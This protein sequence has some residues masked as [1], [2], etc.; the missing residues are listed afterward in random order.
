M[1]TMLLMA[2]LVCLACAMLAEAGGKVEAGLEEAVKLPRQWEYS[3]PLIAPED[4]RVEPSRAQ[5]DPTVVQHDGRWH[6]FMTVKLPGRSAIEYCAFEKWIDAQAAPRTL[7]PVCDTKYYCAPQVF[8][9]RPHGGWVLVYQVGGAAGT[10]KMQVAFSTT[11]TLADP[12]S[13][14]KAEPMLDGGPDDPR[15]VGGLDY[16]VI[17]DER[18]AHL[19]LTSNDG[20]MWLLA[21]N[22]ADFPYGWGDCKLALQGEVFE[23]SHTYRL[24][25]RD[26]YLTIIE[27]DGR[28]YF[29]AYLADRLDGEWTPL[30]DTES[31]PFAGAANIRPAAGVEPWTDNVSHGELLRA[32][33]DETMPLDPA[34]L[35]FVFQG[36]REKDKPGKGYGDYPWRIGILT[37]VAP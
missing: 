8:Y 26:A 18:W 16:W 19:F 13:W 10:D 15:E 9:F 12:H 3:A 24:L 14:T 36:M 21:T 11:E 28:R 6:V 27:Q 34:D 7:L 1:N 29:K 23:A 5:K 31:H 4:R 2:A 22:L 37:P 25:G 17:C 35:R 32:G 33:N 20:R 30:R